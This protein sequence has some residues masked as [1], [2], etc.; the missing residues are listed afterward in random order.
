MKKFFK[1][2][3]NEYDNRLYG[4]IDEGYYTLN[5]AEGN[6]VWL[7]DIYN[8]KKYIIMDIIKN[9]LEYPRLPK[10]NDDQMPFYIIFELKFWRAKLFLT[11]WHITTE[12]IL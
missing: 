12:K 1:V 8:K 3:T 5:S 7:Q 4:R 10:Y 2:K 11:K 9:I 6:S